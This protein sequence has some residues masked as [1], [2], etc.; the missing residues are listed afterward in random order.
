MYIQALTIESAHSVAVAHLAILCRHDISLKVGL[1]LCAS[2]CTDFGTCPHL[3][4]APHSP[5]L[6]DTLDDVDTAVSIYDARDFSNLQLEACIF[7]GLLHLSPAEEPQ[8]A[9]L[10]GTA[11]VGLS[12]QRFERC[13]TSHDGIT[14]LLN[15]CSCLLFTD[16]YILDTPTAGTA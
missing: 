12:R 11:A 3:P 8:V 1:C 10:L 7:E 13:S 9:A 15:F 5:A 16:S 4:I 2:I 14:H 6:R